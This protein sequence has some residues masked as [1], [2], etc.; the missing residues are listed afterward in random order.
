[1]TKDLA[2]LLKSSSINFLLPDC[3]YELNQ[4]YYSMFKIYLSKDELDFFLPFYPAY[5]SQLVH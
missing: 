1:M 4:Y 2:L 5:L 3:D